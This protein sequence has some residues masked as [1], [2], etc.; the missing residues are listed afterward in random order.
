MRSRIGLN[1]STSHSTLHGA[2]LAGR[3]RPRVT[4]T[5]LLDLWPLLLESH[6]NDEPRHRVRDIGAHG[7][8]TR[9]VH[10]HQRPVDPV[11]FGATG[12]GCQDD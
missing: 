5:N 3:W 8:N 10:G 11:R 7:S 2:R 6:T 9:D 4:C 12:G 1:T